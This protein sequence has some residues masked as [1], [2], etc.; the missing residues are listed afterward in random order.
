MFPKMHKKIFLILFLIAQTVFAGEV[1]LTI[2]DAPVGDQALYTGLQ[3][4]ER[5]I[6]ILKKYNIQTVFFSNSRQ[7][8]FDHGLERMNSYAKAGFFI[9]NHT[10]SH[11]GLD[12]TEDVQEYLKDIDK[13]DELLKGFPTFKK[14]F[15]YPFMQEGNTYRKRNTVRRHLRKLNYKNAYVTVDLFDYFVNE[16]IQPVLKAKKKVDLDKACLMI[17][18]LALDGLKHYDDLAKKHLGGSV[19]QV[20]LL[21]ENDIEA[22]CLE[23]LILRLKEN[24]W[25]IISPE[26]AYTE[27]ALVDEPD[28]LYLGGGR[29]AAQLQVKTKKMFSNP[30]ESLK[31]L[32]KEFKKRK[33][34]E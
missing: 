33:I 3:R 12:K 15:R 1:A 24:N 31:A 7:L 26:I 21:H 20:L 4:T 5:F 18:D 30:W 23:K 32:D 28:T 25:A 14:W 10:H 9:G 16:K 34:I 29:V 8:P 11:F 6:S 22:Y 19:K 13:A 17:S 27:P 2:D